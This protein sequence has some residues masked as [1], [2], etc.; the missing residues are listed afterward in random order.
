MTLPDFT[1]TTIKETILSPKLKMRKLEIRKTPSKKANS[2]GD[3]QGVK[4]KQQ[5]SSMSDDSLIQLVEEKST[6]YVTQYQW[7][8]WPDHGVPDTTS[9]DQIK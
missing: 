4:S 1:I 5:E 9:Y 6:Q 8:D 3:V 7:S 2:P